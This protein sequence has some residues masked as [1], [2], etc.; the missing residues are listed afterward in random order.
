M[1]YLG[2]IEPLNRR[3]VKS[4]PEVLHGVRRNGNAALAMDFVDLRRCAEAPIHDL[5]DADRD[6]VVIGRQDFLS[7][8]HDRS[9]ERL[10]KPPRPFAVVDLIVS[11]DGDGVEALTLCFEHQSPRGE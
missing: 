8:E 7:G 2:T 3:G 4:R 10:G 9:A 11:G 6:D 1:T 5:F